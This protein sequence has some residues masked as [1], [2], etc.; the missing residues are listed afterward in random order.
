[1]V[2]PGGYWGAL[3]RREFQPRQL[4]AGA[5]AFIAAGIVMAG[6]AATLKPSEGTVMMIV[7]FDR[8]L[9]SMV[10]LLV[11]LRVI[12]RVNEDA[13]SDWIIQLTAAGASRSLYLIVLSICVSAAGLL[14]YF[15]GAVA[16]AAARG[17]DSGDFGILQSVVAQLP[18][19]P[20]LLWAGAAFAI[21]IAT[22]IRGSAAIYAAL[23]CIVAPW[24]ALFTVIAATRDMERASA[25]FVL[26]GRAAPPLS[27][28]RDWS[29]VGNTLIYTGLLTA[30]AVML[31]GRRIARRT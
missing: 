28:Y 26:V 8:T 22:I 7:R 9:A 5:G 1:M 16:F 19:I 15:C 31:A 29:V 20:L 10:A 3:A 14:F 11:I 18:L 6:V 13:D 23:L 24:V 12:G 25:L 2:K 4:L 30:V 27:I 21:A 17:M